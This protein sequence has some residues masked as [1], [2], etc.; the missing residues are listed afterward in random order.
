MLEGECFPEKLQAVLRQARGRLQEVEYDC[1]G[2]EPCYPALAVNALGAAG[3]NFAIGGD[4]C[5]TIEVTDH[6]GW[7]PFP[8]DYSVLREAAPVAVCTLT[9][10]DLFAEIEEKRVPSISI[11]GSLQTENLGIERLILNLLANP[12]IRFLIVCGTDSAREVGH[13]P[14]QSL[15]ALSESGIDEGGSIPGAKGKRPVLAN[16]SGQA[17]EQFRRAVEVVDLVGVTSVEAIIQAVVD[18]ETR[19]PGA[20]EPFDTEPVVSAIRGSLPQRASIDPAGYFVIHVDRNR[21]KLMLE[22]YRTDGVLDAVIEGEKSAELYFPA[23]E[24]ELVSQLD[25]AAYLGQE[26]ARAEHALRSGE[27]FVQDAAPEAK[28]RSSESACKCHE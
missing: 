21:R 27:P 23:I 18:C 7:P 5:Q 17:V 22:H 20:A 6:E 10:G 13:F 16:V 2:C 3:V 24:K 11:V 9:D 25:H 14:G 15:V 1:I 28:D 19:N 8:G 4:I 12:N 26:L